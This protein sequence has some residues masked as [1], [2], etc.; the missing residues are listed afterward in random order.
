MTRAE[1]FQSFLSCFSK[2]SLP[3]TFSDEN[4]IYFSKFNKTLPPE[5]IRRFILQ[6]EK[7]SSDDEFTEYIACCI[8]P[9]TNDIHAIVYWKGGLLQY[10][11]ILATFDKNGVLIAKKTIA[12]IRSDGKA[13]RRSIAT[14]DEDWIIH[15]VVGEQSE[16]EQLYN[17]QKSKSMSMELMIS[18][19][20]IFSL[21]E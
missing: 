15:I 6:G 21:Q 8:I 10:D 18:G 1:S 19:E 16:D 11:Y 4:I 20:I 5:L 9:D 14:M 13:L 12:G 3:L 7:E 2:E 17:P